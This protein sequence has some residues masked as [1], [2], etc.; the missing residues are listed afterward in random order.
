MTGAEHAKRLNAL[1]QRRQFIESYWKDTFD[2][3]FPIRGSKIG[4][5][6]LDVVG[7]SK[8]KA[9][10]IYDGTLRNSVR[11]MAAALIWGLTPANALWFEYEAE[12]VKGQA[13]K[14]WLEEAS[15]TIWTNIHQSGWDVAAVEFA[16]DYICAMGVVFITEAHEDSNNIYQFETWP[17]HSSYYA[18]SKRGGMIDTVYRRYTL[19]AEQAV[20]DF[21]D[22]RYPLSE[23]IRKDAENKPDELHEFWHAI[24]PRKKKKAAELPIASEHVEAKT[25]KLVRVSGY[26]EQPFS[27]GRS[28]LVPDSVY[29]TGV[30]DDAL[31]DHKTLN[32]LVKYVLMN[33]DMA[34]AGMWGAVD[35]GVLNP[36]TVTIGPRKLV[37]MQ[38]KDSMFPLSPGGKFDLGF[39]LKKDLQGGIR[40]ALLTD[41][42]HPGNEGPEMT[43]YEIARREEKIAK[44]LSPILG[45][46]Q[47]EHLPTV[48]RRCAGI[49]MRVG[50]R[51]VAGEMPIIP[52]MPEG[53][54]GRVN[55]INYKSPFAKAQKAADIMAIER[56][57]SG[58][59][60]LAKSGLTQVVDIYD[61]EEAQREKAQ[62][63]GVPQRLLRDETSVKKIRQD[64]AAAIHAQQ[65]QEREA[66]M[67]EK[68]VPEMTKGMMKGQAAA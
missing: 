51:G 38:S 39:M 43:A 28:V 21:T 26:H 60:N 17:V 46:L 53:L 20:S 36:K 14:K 31:P 6:T 63:L 29:S 52:D 11:G 13:E 59:A 19:S 12:D 44:L 22:K 61:V 67:K 33:A 41:E 62:L 10:R 16:I 54:K 35:D 2:N 56:F 45:R 57:E 1:K 7:D 9:A 18:A 25:K 4:V 42:F 37:V 15:R 40:E 68:I 48:L 24:Y 66:S 50:R 58:F 55:K 65:Q 8:S 23:A 49:A 27:V 5:D 47:S 32:E 3:T 64:R 34:I 30:A